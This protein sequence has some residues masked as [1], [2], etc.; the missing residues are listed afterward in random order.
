MALT[1]ETAAPPHLLRILGTGKLD[2]TFGTTG[3]VLSGATNPT[4]YS[5]YPAGIG[6]VGV[7]DLGQPECH[8]TCQVDGRLWRFLEGK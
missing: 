4:G 5:L 1:G 3:E 7:A 6:R 2:P 8:S